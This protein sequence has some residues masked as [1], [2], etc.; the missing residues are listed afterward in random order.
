MRATAWLTDHPE[1]AAVVADAEAQYNAQKEAITAGHPCPELFDEWREAFSD[2]LELWD[3]FAF[4]GNRESGGTCSFDPLG[5]HRLSVSSDACAW[6]I[7]V[8]SWLR[9]L[10][11]AGIAQT[12]DDLFDPPTCAAATRYVYDRQG[13]SAWTT[14]NN[15]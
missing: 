15:R 8:P 1:D 6:Q 11:A 5:G 10:R 7:N 9:A 2:R 13:L 12:V 14:W 4:I 3:E